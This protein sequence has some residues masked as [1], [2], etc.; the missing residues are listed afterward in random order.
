MTLKSDSGPS[1]ERENRFDKNP[2]WGKWPARFKKHMD[3]LESHIQI[4]NQLIHSMKNEP[5][6]PNLVNQLDWKLGERD[7]YRML[8]KMMDTAKEIIVH[9]RIAAKGTVSCRSMKHTSTG[10]ENYLTIFS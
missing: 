2:L 7:S 8:F 4:L 6:C 9:A 5:D 1:T 10:H 3:I